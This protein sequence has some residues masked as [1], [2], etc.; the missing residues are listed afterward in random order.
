MTTRG[1][2]DP[3]GARADAADEAV[4]SP[5]IAFAGVKTLVL[6]LVDRLGVLRPAY[7]LY[8]RLLPLR[9]RGGAPEAVDGVPVPPRALVVRVAGTADLDWFLESGRR[10]AESIREAV[11]RDGARLE[12]LER[13]L[14][15]GCG[16]GRVTRHWAALDGPALHGT[17]SDGRAIDWCRLN[18]RFAAFDTNG[19]APP[20]RFA[21][22]S[23]D[24]VYG[25]S[26]LTHL[27]QD[28]QRAWLAEL[29]RVLRPG[30]R[31]L[32]SVHGEH[33]LPRLSARE[34]ASFRAG[35]LVV[36]WPDLA[37]TNLCAAF[38]P[39]PYVERAAA[40][41]GLTVADFVQEGARGNP[42]QDLYLLRRA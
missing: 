24:L 37:G 20:L 36:R 25:L 38:H 19:P 29:R 3:L 40:A 8:E 5:S 35:E 27:T 10:A 33:Y 32:L 12:E 4:D 17:D 26:V 30:G 1:C 21:D 34:K 41:E 28:L 31:L 23:F 14:D 13:I 9:H 39:R 22:A 6:R 15:F 16:C 18:L 11:E 42:F 7:R 2:F